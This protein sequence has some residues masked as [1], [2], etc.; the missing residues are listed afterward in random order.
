M[1][2]ENLKYVLSILNIPK[3]G[4]AHAKNLI[5]YCGSAS[6]VFRQK[7]THLVRIPGIGAKLAENIV[8]FKDFDKAEKEVAFIKKHDI[9]PIYFLD[10]EYPRRLNEIADAP[11]LLF[12]KGNT[13][14]NVPRLLAVVG[15]RRATDYGKAVCEKLVE[16]LAPYNVTIVSGLAYGIDYAAHKAALKAGLPTVGVLAHGLDMIYP[17]AH[18]SLAVKMIEQGGLLTEYTSGTGPERE[19]FPE[20][21]RI[22]AGITDG[23]ILVETARKGG[24]LIT[25]EISNSYDREVFAVP[26]RI[27]DESSAGCNH[28]IKV[29]KAFLAESAAD[30]AYYM[31]WDDKQAKPKPAK[32]NLTNLTP[33]EKAI[34][35]CIGKN[36][37]DI[38]TICL[39][40][41]APSHEISVQLLEMEF[42]GLVQAMPGKVYKLTS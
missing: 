26:G 23:L 12:Y 11:I 21:N 37:N 25:A 38:D 27:D 16:E 42:K 2:Q 8:G 18:R 31:G 5:A 36:I 39:E 32:I 13:D 40:L 33:K 30:I 15:T 1:E 28:F 34:V 6:E 4:S 3:I 22:V 17:S 19:H 41:N 35:D 9:K 14:F 10:K 29:N 24:A 20:R 7:K